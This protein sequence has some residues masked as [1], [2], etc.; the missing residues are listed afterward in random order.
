MAPTAMP[1]LAPG[2]R[3]EDE[4]GLWGIGLVSGGMVGGVV[5]ED[6]GGVVEDVDVDVDVEEGFRKGIV[7]ASNDWGEGALKVSFVGF[8][9]FGVAVMVSPQQA[10]RLVLLL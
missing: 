7:C 9:H 3:A 8:M 10:Q 4:G 2:D 6:E 5:V 1:A